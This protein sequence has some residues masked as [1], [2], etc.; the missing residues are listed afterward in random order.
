MTYEVL[1]PPFAK[2]VNR[3]ARLDLFD[4]SCAGRKD[5]RKF[6]PGVTG[7]GRIIA[8]AR[9]RARRWGC[10]LLD[11]KYRVIRIGTLSTARVQ[12]CLW[13]LTAGLTRTVRTEDGTPEEFSRLLWINLGSALFGIQR[14]LAHLERSAVGSV[15]NIT[16]IHALAGQLVTLHNGASKAALVGL[17][18]QLAAELVSRRIRVNAV[19]PGI[20]EAPR[21]ATMPGYTRAR[22]DSCIPLGR[23][24]GTDPSE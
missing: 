21:Y 23:V 20:V 1:D 9:P 10:Y 4:A 7:S 22:G 12:L 24:G 11:R 2:L 19:G 8:G 3:T 16:S 14:A 15:I 6:L 18:R 5:R 13:Q 17:T